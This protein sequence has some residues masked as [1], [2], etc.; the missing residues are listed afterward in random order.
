MNETTEPR[1]PKCG[2]PL[3]PG[4]LGD[5]CPR[6]LLAANLATC[7]TGTGEPS[8][9]SPTNLPTTAPPTVPVAELA[10]CFPQFEILECLGRGGMGIV[11]KARQ[12][13]LNRL[14]ALKVLSPERQ[15]DPQ[16]A[17]RFAREAQALARLNHPS[18]VAIHDFGESGGYYYLLMEYVEGASLREVLRKGRLQASE[19][20]AIVPQICAALQ[21]AHDQGVV[22][23]DIKPEN[24][25]LDRAG[26]VKIAD[27]GLAKIAA[28]GEPAP[29]L[30]QERQIVG[31]PHYMAP[32]QIETPGRV[33]HRADLYSLG[34]VFYE[35]LTGELPL[36]RFQPPSDRAEI[37]A[38]LDPVV[39]HAPGERTRA[40]LPAGQRHSA[41][42]HPGS[43]VRRPALCRPGILR[44]GCRNRPDR[45]PAPGPDDPIRKACA[46]GRGRSRS[47]A[48]SWL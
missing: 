46:S 4:A 37:D 22:H 35:M 11:Y 25:L 8:A 10:P 12:P 19:A 5:S 32:E 3:A 31:T 30:T 17:E 21:Y 18:I 44:R 20:L 39:L 26:H 2:A 45:A 9:T 41:R 38:R 13:R 48:C 15:P 6:C 47:M 24:V 40:P 43:P 34:V 29:A 33:D 16:F 7:V 14:V 23:R 28:P 42:C 27:F 1:C 36:G